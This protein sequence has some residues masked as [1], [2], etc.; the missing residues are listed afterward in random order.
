M[1]IAGEATGDEIG[2]QRNGGRGKPKEDESEPAQSVGRCHHLGLIDF[3]N[4]RPANSAVAR[5]IPLEDRDRGPRREDGLVAVISPH[6]RA[7]LAGF[8]SG[9]D[10]DGIDLDLRVDD[11]RV[12]A[13]ILGEPGVGAEHL[14]GT[15]GVG[16][17]GLPQAGRFA[18][19]LV[20]LVER[21]LERQHADDCVAVDERCGDEA[22]RVHQGWQV[23]AVLA[24]GYCSGAAH[25]ERLAERL[26]KIARSERAGGERRAE[27]DLL[28]HRVEDRARGGI[29]QEDV[30]HA[31][32]FEH[33]P[34]NRVHFGMDAGVGGAIVGGVEQLFRANGVFVATEVAVLKHQAAR[35]ERADVRPHVDGFFC[36]VAIERSEFRGIV[37]DNLLPGCCH[38]LVVDRKFLPC[39]AKRLD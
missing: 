34:E 31:V 24:V 22:R 17:A 6:S 14:V 8:E 23:A 39:L 25:R 7:R 9:A 20:C 28:E 10:G 11:R 35:I 38:G 4:Q 33:I 16:L 30:V 5:G 13:E 3:R 26:G 19:D 1:L 18:D 29:N 2:R 21:Q 12:I 32:S 15:D 37:V 27:I 36:F